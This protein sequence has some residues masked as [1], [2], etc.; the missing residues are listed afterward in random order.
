[1]SDENKKR[2]LM[3]YFFDNCYNIG[4]LH[5]QSCDFALDNYCYI[6]DENDIELHSFSL[7]R[8]EKYIVP[9]VQD[10]MK[11]NPDLRFIASP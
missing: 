8:D 6:P 10:A 2:F 7:A 1:M 3:L 4:R 9:L 5:I 11:V